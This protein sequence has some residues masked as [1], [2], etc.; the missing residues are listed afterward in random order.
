MK[1]PLDSADSDSPE[2]D[3][4][5]D[6]KYPSSISALSVSDRRA[7]SP[8]LAIAEDTRPNSPRCHRARATSFVWLVFAQSRYGFMRSDADARAC[9]GFR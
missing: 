1:E 9:A 2:L 5:E 8:D 3:L 6:A 7:G 4:P